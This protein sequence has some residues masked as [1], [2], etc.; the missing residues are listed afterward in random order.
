MGTESV[1]ISWQGTESGVQSKIHQDLRGNM[2]PMG[3]TQ[4]CQRGPGDTLEAS[5]HS[6]FR[7]AVGQ[8]Q[9][10][11]LQG[12]LCCLLPLGSC[13]ELPPTVRVSISSILF[14]SG[15]PHQTPPGQTAQMDHQRVG[16]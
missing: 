11:Q 4:T 16:I 5:E 2:E 14:L 7:G 15:S 6:Q 12:T 1:T 13:V 8:L 9:W 10:L 3:A